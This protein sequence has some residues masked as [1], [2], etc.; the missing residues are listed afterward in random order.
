MLTTA[1]DAYLA[2]RRASGFALRNQGVQL[3][4]FAAFSEARGH[5]YIHAAIAIEWAGLGQSGLQR[6]PARD[7]D[8]I[9]PLSPCGG[10]TPRGAA[11]NL[12]DG[13]RTAAHP[14]HPDD[15]RYPANHQRCRSVDVPC[16]LRGDVQH[17]VCLAGVHRV[18][19]LRSDSA[20]RGRHHARRLGDSTDQVPQEPP[21][22]LARDG[23]GWTGTISPA[24]A[25]IRANGRPCVRVGGTKTASAGRCRP[26]V[27]DRGEGGRT[28]K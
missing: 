21:R 4:S 23:P 26:R 13:E 19:C 14:V 2:V 9:R 25:P 18:T 22:A 15:D 1:A 8:S 12:R 3:K 27:Q 17:I 24:A 7:R 28:A 16:D 10:R 11:G 5:H 20:A 6:A